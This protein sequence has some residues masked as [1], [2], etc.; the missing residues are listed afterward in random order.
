MLLWRTTLAAGINILPHFRFCIFTD[1][2]IMEVYIAMDGYTLPCGFIAKEL[3]I[4]FPN[5]EYNHVLLQPPLNQELSAVDR[6]TVR[7]TTQHLNNLSYSDGDMPYEN[8]CDILS[9]YDEYRVY[10][11]SKVVLKLLQTVLS[12]SVVINI[13]DMGYEMPSELPDANCFR[14]HNPR[15]CAKAKSIAIKNF[16]KLES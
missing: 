14:V 12:T 8:L 13:Q 3:C 5:G 10:T 9:K 1:E 7:Y 4:M 15:Y 16:V 6:R 2:S 11:Y